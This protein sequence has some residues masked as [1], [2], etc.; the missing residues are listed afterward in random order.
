MEFFFCLFRFSFQGI[1]F[2]LGDSGCFV[3]FV[4]VHDLA[5][6]SLLDDEHHDDGG[7]IEMC[8]LFLF[9]SFEPCPSQSER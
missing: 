7:W 2:C 5:P 9:F 3:F 1:V 4:V 6:P 8:F